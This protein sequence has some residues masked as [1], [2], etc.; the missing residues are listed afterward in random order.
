MQNFLLEYSSCEYIVP[1]V[2]WKGR[3]QLIV[4]KEVD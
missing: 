3:T 2:D 4:A 1:V